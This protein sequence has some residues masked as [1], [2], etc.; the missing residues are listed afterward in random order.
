MQAVADVHDTPLRRLSVAPLGLGVGW[1]VHARMCSASVKPMF[2]L[3]MWR[4]T[5]VQK[6]AGMHDTPS[7]RLAAAPVGLG[8]DCT[9]QVLVLPSQ[10]SAKVTVVAEL[11]L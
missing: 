7:K 10:P 5:A 6:V 2:E 4:P 9:A 3:F 11:F 8:V 1:T